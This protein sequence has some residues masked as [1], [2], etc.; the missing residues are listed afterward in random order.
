[1]AMLEQLYLPYFRNR[2]FEE[3]KR[4]KQK[5]ERFL[6]RANMTSINP[7]EIVHILGY[8][9]HDWW[10]CKWTQRTFNCCESATR[11]VNEYGLCYSIS[12]K[13]DIGEDRARQNIP[14]T[15]FRFEPFMN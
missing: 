4:M 14:G 3:L 15:T 6:Q 10:L 1:M 13:P 8:K 11:I 2:I 9:C 7:M 12:P 5:Y